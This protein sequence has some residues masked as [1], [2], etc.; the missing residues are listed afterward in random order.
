MKAT[1]ERRDLERVLET[2][3]MMSGRSKVRHELDMVKITV[4][5]GKM[6]VTSFNGETGVSTSVQAGGDIGKVTSFCLMPQTLMS[7]VRLMGDGDIVLVVDEGGSSMTVDY[8]TG[9]M[10]MGI[11]PADGF[12]AF[13]MDGEYAEIHIS[14]DT[15]SEWARLSQKFAADDELRPNL[16]GMLVHSGNG[17]TGFCASD[18]HILIHESAECAGAAD[19]SFII[20]R[21][22]FPALQKLAGTQSVR[23]RVSET[24]AVFSGGGMSIYTA[25]VKGRY[26]DFRRVI[27]P[28]SGNV[29]TVDRAQFGSALRKARGFT[30]QQRL[31]RMSCRDGR[32]S[33]EASDMDSAS[34]IVESVE[35]DGD[36][37][38]TIGCSCSMMMS[39][40]EAASG[41]QVSM[42]TASPS[43]PV[44]ITSDGCPSRR[45][46][47][48]PMAI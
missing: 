27:P 1:V 34:R 46:V 9:K 32:L 25:L 44:L 23:I 18:S 19:A 39:A 2:G 11:A 22:A 40:M 14:G 37:P 41:E 16:S 43:K 3:G 35:A 15:V 31:I 13:G 17:E 5:D 28:A 26:P 29:V 24:C 47:V 10:T 6:R 21:S 12:P 7:A 4:K 30:G 8:G 45:I 20:P 38:Y 42:A 48:M 33:V 36:F